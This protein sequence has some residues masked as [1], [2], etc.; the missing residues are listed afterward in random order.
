[1]IST[2]K[3]W[4]FIYL[5]ILVY[6]ILF[7]SFIYLFIQFFFLMPLKPGVFLLLGYMGHASRSDGPLGRLVAYKM[8]TG[9]HGPNWFGESYFGLQLGI[10]KRN[11][12]MYM[13]RADLWTLPRGM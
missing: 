5:F 2:K 7:Y 6:F 11:W 12:D 13:Y 8:P 1:M 3:K 9:R 10:I 4:E